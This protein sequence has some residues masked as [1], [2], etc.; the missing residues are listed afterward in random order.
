M[1]EIKHK[2]KDKNESLDELKNASKKYIIESI[3]QKSK[4]KHI[5]NYRNKHVTLQFLFNNDADAIS[6]LTFPYSLL[7]FL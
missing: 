5:S 6:K 2:H 7:L 4:Y 1:N 3:N